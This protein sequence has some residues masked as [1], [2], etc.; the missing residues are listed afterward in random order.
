MKCP[1]CHRTE[2]VTKLHKPFQL[3]FGSLLFGILGGAIGGLFWALGQE[4]KY[5]CAACERIFFAHTR[6]SRVFWVL[7]LITYTCI[8]ALLICG[9]VVLL[10]H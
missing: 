7:A 5:R 4:D 8:A 10:R 2:D 3:T 6:V 1:G 9:I